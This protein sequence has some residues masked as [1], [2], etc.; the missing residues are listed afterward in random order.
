[1]TDVLTHVIVG[2]ILGTILSLRVDWIRA[3]LV[4]VVMVGAIL[5]DLTKVSLVLPPED[6]AAALGLT[7]DWFALH[8]P[9]GV[10]IT[11]G[12][13]TLFV[14]EGSRQ[15]VF[16]LL[17]VGAASHFVLDSLLMSPSR[18]SYVLF[19]PFHTVL[20]PLPM[21]I[22]SS[23]RW[24]AVVAAVVALVLWYVKR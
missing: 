1:M 14:H 23:D 20:V 16:A 18:F 10:V 4:T 21:Y 15:R 22:L 19:W 24:P 12:I 7:F 5:P 8:T 13:V 9:F 2:Y 3:P 6:V 11:A 17:L